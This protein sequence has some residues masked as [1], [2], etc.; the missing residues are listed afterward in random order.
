MLFNK[1][2]VV[3]SHRA[4]PEAVKV[5]LTKPNLHNP[6]DRP[7]GNVYNTLRSRRYVS[8]IPPSAAHA[9]SLLF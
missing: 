3:V 9:W 5:Y 2:T 6:G 1:G 7:G 4:G 8:R